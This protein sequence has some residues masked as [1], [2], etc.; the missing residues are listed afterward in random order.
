[1]PHAQNTR[2]AGDELLRHIPDTGTI[3]EPALVVEDDS[4]VTWDDTCDMLVVGAGI[5]GASAALKGSEIGGMD[6]ILADRFLGG[7]SSGMSGGVVYAG[8][9]TRVQ[10]EVG[11]IDTVDS[12]D[13]YMRFEAG[14]IR[15]PETIRRFAERSPGVIDWLEAR[16]AVFGGPM[17]T[18]KTGY[19]P[20]DKFIYF[21]GNEIV[22][23]YA[24]SGTPAPRGHRAIPQNKADFKAFSG[25]I[26]MTALG[27]TIAADKTIRRM[28]QTWARRL[29][30]DKT[31]R[32][33][34]VEMARLTPDSAAAK[35][36]AEL[37]RK[38]VPNSIIAQLLT[39][40]VKLW[41]KLTKIERQEAKPVMVRV[42]RGVVLS[43]GGFGQNRTMLAEQAPAF[44][45]LP[46]NGQL[47][48]DGS[49][50]R[51]GAS[52]GARMG[53]MHL[54]SPWRFLAPPVSLV[55]GLMVDRQGH[56]IVNEQLYGANLGTAITMEGG[57]K[58]WLVVDAAVM[59][60]VRQE[61]KDKSLWAFQRLP[62]KFMIFRS[63]K[64]ATPEA[65]EAKC[66]FT[67]GALTK[68]LA[69]HN[70]LLHEGRPDAFGKGDSYRALLETGP[71]YAM[72]QSHSTLN[73]MGMITLGGLEVVEETG[74]AL[75][76]DGTPI[77][78]LYA[79]GR[80]AVGMCSQ[81]YV[82]GMSLGDGIFSGW[83]AAEAI[84]KA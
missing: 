6:I 62:V 40:Q 78:G 11:V 50:V 57:G 13:E 39:N 49:A 5:A 75:R 15:K 80:S 21:S 12:L 77:P 58:A 51:M 45:Q 23:A 81:N 70:A 31:G 3:I 43:T 69:E 59:A 55:K 44:S 61:L 72:D 8:G 27:K 1:M 34:G 16:G 14:Q 71:F 66:G 25:V 20:A 65:L 26:L 54:C 82:S 84:A 63:K 10:K 53:Q 9:G 19:P 38:S 73:P 37:Y 67:P 74:Q 33:I 30:V 46:N 24:T 76:D 68:T 83:T 35:T 48:D 22:P 32:V 18:R 79:A 41:T 52:V 7:G 64:A 17:E 29:V 36:H 28:F 56:R 4:A 47:G 42:R 2:A 60:K